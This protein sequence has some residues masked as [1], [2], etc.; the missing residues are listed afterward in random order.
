MT[1]AISPNRLG[2]GALANP[3]GAPVRIVHVGLGAFHRAHQA[4]YTAHASDASQ[5]GIAAYTGRRPDAA[6]ML[7]AQGCVYTVVIRDTD[8]DRFEHVG[9]IVRTVPGNDLNDFV[10][11]VAAPNVAMITLTITEAGY[12]LDHLGRLDLSDPDV[13]ADL[14]QLRDALGTVDTGT[15]VLRTAL[16]RV[17]FALNARRRAGSPPLAIVPCDNLSS[18]GPLT[19]QILTEMAKRTCRPLATWLEKEIPFVSTSVDRITPRVTDTDIDDV[20]THTGWQDMAPVVTEPFTDW[21]LSGQFPAGRPAWERAGARFVD[22][23]EPY[24]N[25]KLWLLN[26]AHTLLACA[27][28]LAGHRTVQTAMA[29]PTIIEAV[30]AWWDE[31]AHH[32]Q[33]VETLRYRDALQLRFKNERIVHQLTQIAENT[34]TKLCHRVIPIAQRERAL[35]RP[36][37][38][39]ARVLGAWIAASQAKSL[40]AADAA[41]GEDFATAIATLDSVLANDSDFVEAVRKSALAWHGSVGEREAQ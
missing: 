5:W 16:A 33:G 13:A 14:A 6:I 30:N 12:P 28:L 9:S 8:G 39:A 29:D 38:A 41:A 21:V 10:A 4:W 3:A 31:A 24:E 36:G 17:L 35:N 1:D 37:S 15:I 7:D 25:R 27:G 2:R 40:G 22:D 11:T 20:A 18:N 26:G 23:I 32:L 19:R 34:P